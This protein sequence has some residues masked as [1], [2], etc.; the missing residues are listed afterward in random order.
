MSTTHP[1]RPHNPQVPTPLTL[2]LFRNRRGG[3]GVDDGGA[4]EIEQGK[5]REE[6]EGVGAA[7]GGLGNRNGGWGS[8]LS[9]FREGKRVAG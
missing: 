3:E 9:L 2:D 1:S 8:L 4:V 7:G 6:G 5:A